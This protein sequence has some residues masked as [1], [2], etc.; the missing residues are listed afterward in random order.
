MG[1]KVQAY[2]FIND[3]ISD[4]STRLSSHKCLLQK[5]ED[6][7]EWI[8]LDFPAVMWLSISVC[9]VVLLSDVVFCHAVRVRRA[10]AD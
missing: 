8:L 1:S 10:L 6:Y 7:T 9:F 3:I 2:L 5:S 4:K